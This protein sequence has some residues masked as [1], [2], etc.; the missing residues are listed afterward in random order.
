LFNPKGQVQALGMSRAQWSSSDGR[1]SHTMVHQV[2]LA[3]GKLV[4][5]FGSHQTPI[6]SFAV[7]NDGTTLAGIVGR[8]IHLW[9]TATGKER[10]S[11]V[12]REQIPKEQLDIFGPPRPPVLAFSPNGKIIAAR[13][14]RQAAAELRVASI[15][16]WEAAS[17]KARHCIEWKFPP[18]AWAGG[19]YP[20]GASAIFDDNGGS[21]A[22]SPDGKTLAL[23][24][25]DTIRLWDIAE[26]REIRRVG[27][28][29]QSEFATFSPDGK[30][31]AARGKDGS[32]FLWDV[33]TG[34]VLRPIKTP[35]RITCFRFS[36]DGRTLATGSDDTSVLLWDLTQLLT[37][38]KIARPNDAFDALWSDLA[39]DDASKA[40]KAILA[41]GQGGADSVA[42]L[43]KRLEPIAP[44]DPK[45]MRKLLTDLDS[46][47]FSVREKARWELELLGDLAL[48]VLREYAGKR[49]TLEAQRRVEALLEKR[50]GL[51]QESEVLRSLRAIEA[52]EQIGSPAA[53]G[54]LDSLAEGLP[55]HRVTVSAR[56]AAI[57]LRVRH[58]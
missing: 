40:G 53:R 56:E 28:Q 6:G 12:W 8:H 23:G 33:P 7:A 47:Q 42:E 1:G 36:P 26:N 35:A 43:K 29:V 4:R 32:V 20:G 34:T 10:A 50:T 38:S 15:T 3:T 9:N 41:L 31:L 54:V 57:R 51:V 14:Y 19:G 55:E 21:L 16:L 17:G 46:E 49:L 22:I 58:R 13:G 44:A 25:G 30:L 52:L 5:S 37:A 27:G 39:S 18:T 2:D 11:F 45:L 24:H 48:P